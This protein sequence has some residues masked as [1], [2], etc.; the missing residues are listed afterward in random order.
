MRILAITDLHGS[1]AA[2]DR[3]MNAA[4]PVDMVLLGGDITNFGQPED[5][6]RLVG[7]AQDSGAPVWAVAG[8][9]DSA[10]IEQRLVDLCVSLHGRGVISQG[11]A[12]HG[13]SAMPPWGHKMYQFT[14]PQLA[15]FLQA[16]HAQVAGAGRHVL[17]THCPPHGCRL[18]RTHFFQHVGSTSAR[19][20]IERTQPALVLCGHIHE[21]RGI[22]QIGPTVVVNCGAAKSGYFA[23][24]KIEA[25]GEVKVELGRA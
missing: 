14:E 25:E 13:L 22:D 7:L 18:D 11:I 2:L 15:E 19:D 4:G 12:L 23:V 24:A 21:G 20:F 10:E 5:V 8:N 17:L 1:D 3:I 16:G 6:E 9:C